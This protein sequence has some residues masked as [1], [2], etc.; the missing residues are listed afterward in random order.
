MGRRGLERA[1][2]R[3]ERVLDDILDGILADDPL[4]E[5]LAHVRECRRCGHAYERAQRVRA[6]LRQLPRLE[7]DEGFALRLARL[8][9]ETSG[10]EVAEVLARLPRV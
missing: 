3:F 8:Y 2:L 4:R 10:R 9:L 5:A 1:C 7:A 6:M